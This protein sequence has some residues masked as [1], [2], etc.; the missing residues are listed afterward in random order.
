VL[1]CRAC[2]IFGLGRCKLGDI[3][4]EARRG[5]VVGEVGCVGGGDAL[6]VGI[7]AG[8]IVVTIIGV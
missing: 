2:W 8:R 6:W 5:S 7:R 4:K 3:G 1:L